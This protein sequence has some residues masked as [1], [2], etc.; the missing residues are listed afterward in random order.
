MISEFKDEYNWLS[1][2]FPVKIILNNIIYPS[3]E[4]AYMSEKSDDLLWKLYCSN[5][6]NKAWQVKRK[7]KEIIYKTNWDEIKLN[8]MRLCVEQK[9]S[10]EPF[11]TK[12]IETKNEYLQ[13]G[14][15]WN[16]KFWGFC[17]KTNTG[18]NNL[19]KLIMDFREKL[20]NM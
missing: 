8:V 14:N 5:S 19:G 9:F 1:N 16:D 10:V 4:H 12:L 17:L 7:S 2:F 13:E 3:V 15:M 6:K 20:K 11:K 18:E